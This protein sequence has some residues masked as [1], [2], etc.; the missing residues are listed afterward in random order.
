MFLVELGGVRRHRAVEEQGHVRDLA[1]L[2]ESMERPQDR[3]GPAD[4]KG[5]DQE[6]AAAAHGLAHHLGEPCNQALLTVRS[7]TIGGLQDDELRGRRW[8]GRAHEQ[9]GRAADVAAEEDARVGVLEA[10]ARRAQDVPH[11]VEAE[12]EPADRMRDGPRDGPESVQRVGRVLLVVERQGG[13]VARETLAVGVGGVLL[14][15]VGGVHPQDVEQVRGGLCAVDRPVEARANEPR[16]PARVVQMGVGQD[17][18]VQAPGADLEVP[19]V[20]LAVVLELL[21]Q[22]AIDQQ[23]CAVVGL[24]ERA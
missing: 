9:I 8:P 14:L 6:D 2:L 20:A 16:D 12:L 18:A 10:G 7:R 11:P 21:E 13:E 4:R 24:Q 15:D 19:P 23:A 17:H 5:R 1:V 22:A 3:L